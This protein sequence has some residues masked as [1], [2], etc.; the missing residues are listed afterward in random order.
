MRCLKQ[1]TGLSDKNG[2]EIFEGDIV[3]YIGECTYAYPVTIKYGIA[4]LENSVHDDL[5]HLANPSGDYPNVL[6]VIGTIHDQKG[7]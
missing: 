5:Y 1:F 3:N 2:K 6:E 4:C 7:E